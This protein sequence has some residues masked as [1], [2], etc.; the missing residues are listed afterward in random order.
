M[1]NKWF[2]STALAVGLVAV[3]AVASAETQLRVFGG[4][5]AVSDSDTSNAYSDRETEYDSGF[6]IGAAYGVVHGSWVLEGEVAYRESDFERTTDSG[7][8]SYTD[9]G[10][11]NSFSIM[12]NAWYNFPISGDW[13]GY[14][15]G[16]IGLSSN[17]RQFDDSSSRTEDIN[18]LAWQLGAGVNRTTESG[19]GYGVG[20]RYFQTDEIDANAIQMAGHSILFELTRRY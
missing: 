7:A 19:F 1:G 13:N 20:Y 3:P 4:L 5:N 8:Y 10:T 2:A 16:G 12:A 11:T 9:E 18:R 17:S 15:G 14:A 6:V